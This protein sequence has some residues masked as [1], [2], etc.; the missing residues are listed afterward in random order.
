MTSPVE[1]IQ[2]KCPKCGAL[3]EDWHR[4]SINIGLDHFDEEYIEEA[5]TSTCPHCKH[6]VSHE[7]LIVRHDGVW[8][9]RDGPE[10]AP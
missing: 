5:T 6:K 10:E 4:A 1:K 3:Y 2:V 9:L 8:E 7:V